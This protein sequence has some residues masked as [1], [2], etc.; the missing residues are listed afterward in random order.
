[1]RD[2]KKVIEK[3]FVNFQTVLKKV[4]ENKNILSNN[5]K[6]IIIATK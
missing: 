3:R 1:M 2:N 5:T 4:G 6:K